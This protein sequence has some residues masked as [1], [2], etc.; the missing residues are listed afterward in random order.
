VQGQP[1]EDGPPGGWGLGLPPG[2]HPDAIERPPASSEPFAVLSLVAG[3]LSIFCSWCCLG[4]LVAPA[5]L[6]LGAVA[7]GR[8]PRGSR[9]VA[10]A[11]LITSAAGLAIWLLLQMVGLAMT[12][13][14]MRGRG[15]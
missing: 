14:S 13:G 10:I 6:V 5:G 2:V 12:F 1:P 4:M 15:P 9:G 3:I 11:G 8:S 7:M